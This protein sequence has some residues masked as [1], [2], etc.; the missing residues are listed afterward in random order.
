MSTISAA[1][2]N[3]LRKRTDMPLMD[4]KK[5][6]T[7]TAG[8]MDKAI[9]WLRSQNTKL[10]AKRSMNETAEGRVG[11][12]I[13]PATENA[14]ILEMRCESAPV[15]KSEQFIG[16]VNQLARSDGLLA[17]M[18]TGQSHQRPLPAAGHTAG[19]HRVPFIHDRLDHEGPGAAKGG[20]G[21]SVIK[22]GPGP[23]P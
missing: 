17:G 14:A 3:E 4:C 10:Q 21:Q 16:L 18:R 11:V 5:A 15:T 2:V 8:D 9:A 12:Y 19:A 1:A 7:E 20:L 23:L 6:L 22:L 13:D